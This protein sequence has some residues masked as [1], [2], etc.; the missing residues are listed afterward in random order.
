MIGEHPGEKLTKFYN[1]MLR[2][3]KAVKQDKYYYDYKG[4]KKK[5]E[6][7]TDELGNI[8]ELEEYFIM[9]KKELFSLI[10]HYMHL[11]NATPKLVY[12]SLVDKESEN[13]RKEDEGFDEWY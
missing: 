1:K 10:E 8:Q 2:F 3:N 7:L 4:L 12:D 6:A 11:Q 9:D 13:Q 5:V